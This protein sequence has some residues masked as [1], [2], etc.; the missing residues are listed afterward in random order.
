M[1]IC[2]KGQICKYLYITP[3]FCTILVKLGVVKE[4]DCLLCKLHSIAGGVIYNWSGCGVVV[5][6]TVLRMTVA[7]R[8]M[9]HKDGWTKCCCLGN[10][11]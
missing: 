4:M 11:R 7:C 9:Q 6:G 3:I 2:L 1:H 5:L 10:L 8:T